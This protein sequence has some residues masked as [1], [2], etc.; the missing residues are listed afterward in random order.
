M[1]D[2]HEDLKGMFEYSTDWFDSTTIRGLVDHFQV[3]LTRIAAEPDQRIH[4]LNLSLGLL[5]VLGKKSL[6]FILR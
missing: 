5:Q 6:R 3:L 2:T 4:Q 1:I